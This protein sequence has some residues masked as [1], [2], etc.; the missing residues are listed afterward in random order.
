MSRFNH[1]GNDALRGNA[2]EPL[3]QRVPLF[4]SEAQ[5]KEESGFAGALMNS[6]AG[7]GIPRGFNPCLGGFIW[8]LR[9]SIVHCGKNRSVGISC[10]YV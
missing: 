5:R 3:G 1:P 9:Q 2:E 10:A 6:P 8:P 7:A 4:L